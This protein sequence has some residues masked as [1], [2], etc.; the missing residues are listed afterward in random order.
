MSDGPPSSLSRGASADPMSSWYVAKVEDELAQALKTARFEGS[1]GA[2][3]NNLLGVIYC[4]DFSNALVRSPP[5]IHHLG[6]TP[7]GQATDPQ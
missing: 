6:I 1:Q 4:L 5:I 3:G 7:R 2:G